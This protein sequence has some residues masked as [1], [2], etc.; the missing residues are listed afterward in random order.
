MEEKEIFDKI[1]K[2]LAPYAKN[3]EALAN[4]QLETS[5]LKDLEVNSSRLVDIIL[6][7]EDQFEIEFGDGEASKVNTLATAVKLIQ[8]KLG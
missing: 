7:F 1:V 3:K 4:V 5:I 8:S 6:A 2:V